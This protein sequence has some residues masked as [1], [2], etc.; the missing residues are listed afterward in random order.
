MYG[1]GLDTWVKRVLAISFIVLV[2]AYYALSGNISRINEV[3][4]IPIIDYAVIFLL[5]AIYLLI[6]WI[7]NVFQR[8]AQLEAGTD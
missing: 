1:L 5:Y 7:I 3:I 4:N 8:P 6:T 2:V